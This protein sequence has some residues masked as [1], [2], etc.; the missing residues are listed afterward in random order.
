MKV[1]RIIDESFRSG[2]SKNGKEYVIA[3]VELENGE[4]ASAFQP[5]KAGDDGEVTENEYGFQF[6]LSKPNLAMDA[7]MKSLGELHE[8]VD[9]LL[10]IAPDEVIDPDDLP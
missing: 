1:K 7:V 4:T 10:G 8:K 6:K 9:K 5:V 2:I 3:K